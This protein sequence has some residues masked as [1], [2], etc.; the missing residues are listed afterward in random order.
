[1]LDLLLLAVFILL[2]IQ[3]RYQLPSPKTSQWTWSP[4][5]LWF[6][7]RKLQR[8]HAPHLSTVPYN[9]GLPFPL[10]YGGGKWEI[11]EQTLSGGPNKTQLKAVKIPLWWGAT[12]KKGMAILGE[13]MENVPIGKWKLIAATQKMNPPNSYIMGVVLW[14]SSQ[15]HTT[16]NFYWNSVLFPCT[17]ERSNPCPT[18]LC[19]D[20][21]AWRGWYSFWPPVDDYYAGRIDG[22]LKITRSGAEY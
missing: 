6:H 3:D 11:Y 20:W 1:M 19:I 21:D 7:G 2:Q 13:F 9:L 5:K 14:W 18:M 15:C 12:Y 8:S 10:R 22:G 17:R 16:I 4:I